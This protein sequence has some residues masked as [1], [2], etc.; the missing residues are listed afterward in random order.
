MKTCGECAWYLPDYKRELDGTETLL[1]GGVC[2]WVPWNDG[3]G[4]PQMGW[5]VR[6]S[7]ACPAFEEVPVDVPAGSIP[8]CDF[9][10][11]SIPLCDVC[12]RNFQRCAHTDGFTWAKLESEHG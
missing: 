7:R 2:R 4:G 1:K 3:D 8:L 12:G 5:L 9:P 6:A 10:A 11:G